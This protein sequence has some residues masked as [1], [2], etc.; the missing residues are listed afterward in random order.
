MQI[1]DHSIS[2]PVNPE[3]EAK[4]A[5]LLELCFDGA[6]EGRTYFKQMPQRR[7]CAWQ[8][9]DL[10]GHVGIE[11]RIIHV[12]DQLLSV[13]GI[14]DLC[15][16]PHARRTGLGASLLDRAEH[17]GRGQSF[18]LAM[19]DDTRLYDTQGY[20]RVNDALV[21]FLAIDDLRSHSLIERDCSDFFMCKPLSEMQWPR[22]SIDMLGYLF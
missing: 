8:D 2:D 18:A 15:V 21:T 17:T 10:I 9:T 7:L 6:H 11:Y 13:V 1:T 3:Q 14:V 12:G 22:G 5:N 16:A 19:A 20:Q 4:L